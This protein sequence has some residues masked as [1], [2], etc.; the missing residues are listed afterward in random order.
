MEQITSASVLAMDPADNELGDPNRFLPLSPHDFVVLLL[1][2]EGPLH[3]Y[4]I[5]KASREAKGTPT[6]ELGSLYRIVRRMTRDGLI[7]EARVDQS[8]TTRKRRYY[9]ATA[10]GRAAARAEAR[11]LQALL[12]ANPAMRLLEG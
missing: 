9:R 6:L 2:S 11:R 12:D 7:E 1:L 4:G 3:G 5:V 10:L 8:H